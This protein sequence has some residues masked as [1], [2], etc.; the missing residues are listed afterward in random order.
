MT[1][2]NIVLTAAMVTGLLATSIGGASA[3]FPGQDTVTFVRY[4]G[5]DT[6]I[7]EMRPNGTEEHKVLG[8]TKGSFI[9]A[10]AM[11]PDGRRVVFSASDGIQ[12]D[13]FVKR[14][15]GGTKRI[16]DTP[17]RNEHS[18][19]WSPDGE[20]VVFMETDEVTYSA[21]VRRD[22]D[23]TR[24]R[25]IH[26]TEADYLLFPSVSPDGQR[27]L[28]SA[29]RGAPLRGDGNYELMTKKMD[30]TGRRWLTETP[31]NEIAGDWSPDGDRVAFLVQTITKMTPLGGE[32]APQPGLGGPVIEQPVY[33]IRSEGGG[34]RLITEKP[35]ILG[36]VMYTPDGKRVMF[37][38]LTSETMD[39][40]STPVGGGVLKRLTETTK[41]YNAFDLFQTLLT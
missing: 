2:R 36:R 39:L 18:P 1:L 28:F 31:R 15:G 40:F 14:I 41:T 11:A 9:Y 34:K 20:L 12:F 21:I 3:S 8:P 19:M 38:R 22:A 16:T 23:G 6:R 27:V 26:R 10:S 4:N 24:R 7:F 29:P 13:L 5:A 30:G 33:S 32:P 17:G 37:S 35:G 25:E